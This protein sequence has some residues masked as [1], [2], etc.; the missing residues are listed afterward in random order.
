MILYQL[1]PSLTIPALVLLLGFL[2]IPAFSQS[3]N[4]IYFE[5]FLT[6]RFAKPSN[7][8]WKIDSLCPISTSVV[9]RRVFS[10]YGAVFSAADSVVLPPTCIFPGEVEVKTFQ[11][12]LKTDAVAM[13]NVRITL[14][15]AAAAK[16]N[17]AIRDAEAMRLRI[18]PLDGAIAGDRTYGQTLGLWNSR[19]F[20]ALEHW[21]RLHRLT[22][23]D[24]NELASLEPPKKIEKI[25]EWESR[26]L[27]FSPNRARSILTSTAPPGVSQHLSFLAFDVV[28]YSRA[29]VRS[30]LNRHG[31][32]QTIIDDPPHFTFLGVAETELPGRGLRAVRK[33]GYI[34]WVPNLS[35]AFPTAVQPT[36]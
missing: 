33:G 22:E 28:E 26:G 5:E 13:G 3:S 6:R 27:F 23:A 8:D 4:G 25:L 1:A 24:R 2:A 16:L 35:P 30:V 17:A 7:K 14:Q 9:A 31:W 11:K 29:E 36:R 20:P 10:S 19:V 18:S 15:A 32:F 34:Y 21:I 12:D